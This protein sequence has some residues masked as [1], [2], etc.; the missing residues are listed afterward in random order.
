[1][2][3]SFFVGSGNKVNGN[4]NRPGLPLGTYGVDLTTG[5]LHENS[6]KLTQ[7]FSL[8]LQKTH[9]LC[10]KDLGRSGQRKR[11]VSHNKEF[12]ITNVCF[13]SQRKRL[14]S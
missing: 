14:G 12:R 5:G 3:C 9:F 1:M 8:V 7:L 4:G 10:S 13:F 11:N 6:A 2:F